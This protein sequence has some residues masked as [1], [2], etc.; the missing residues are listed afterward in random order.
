MLYYF[1]LVLFQS[2]CTLD[3]LVKEQFNCQS[4]FYYV[5]FCGVEKLVSS[6]FIFCVYF[7]L[8][9]VFDRVS[10]QVY[11][12][13]NGILISRGR[14]T[15]SKYSFFS[16][17]E[18]KYIEMKK[19]KWF[20]ISTQEFFWSIAFRLWARGMGMREPNLVM[21]G[22][23]LIFFCDWRTNQPR[24]VVNW[25]NFIEDLESRNTFWARFYVND[26]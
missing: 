21:S 22:G 17:S 1:F 4:I 6:L 5:Q 9:H 3:H 24:F 10:W 16:D 19:I 25:V 2:F 18:R 8:C 14:K 11:E 20:F 7:F 15:L 23:F 12:N 13:I 26:I